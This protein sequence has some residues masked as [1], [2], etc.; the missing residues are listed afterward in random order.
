MLGDWAKDAAIGIGFLLLSV[1]CVSTAALPSHKEASAIAPA[2]V[3]VQTP[4]PGAAVHGV[5]RRE[6]GQKVRPFRP[7]GHHT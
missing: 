3:I 5:W 7:S 4:T 6:T 1:C 2:A